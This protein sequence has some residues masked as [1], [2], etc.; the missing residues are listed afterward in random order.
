MFWQLESLPLCNLDHPGDNFII[1]T[2]SGAANL[3]NFVKMM[4]FQLQWRKLSFCTAGRDLHCSGSCV[5]AS[6]ATGEIN[7]SRY[8]ESCHVAIENIFETRQNSTQSVGNMP[9]LPPRHL[10]P[11]VLQIMARNPKYDQFPPKGHHNEEYPQSTTKMPWKPQ[12]WPIS[13]SQNSIK[14]W[15]ISK[16]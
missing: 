2:T 16:L 10:L 12:I 7:P 13:L 8:F 15:K 5:N 1:L 6:R 4:T 14:I 11:H 3:E 9:L